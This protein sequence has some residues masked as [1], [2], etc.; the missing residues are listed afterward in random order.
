MLPDSATWPRVRSTQGQALMRR[1]GH[2][3]LSGSIVVLPHQV[4]GFVLVATVS[5]WARYVWFS[6]HCWMSN[7]CEGTLFVRGRYMCLFC[8]TLSSA[9]KSGKLWVDTNK[10]LFCHALKGEA[11][12]RPYHGDNLQGPPGSTRQDPRLVQSKYTL[13]RTWHHRHLPSRACGPQH[14]V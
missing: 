12:R 7:K 1:G 8:C 5:A 2:T 14:V 10:R 4:P 3:V 9:R 11:G 13:V 6:V